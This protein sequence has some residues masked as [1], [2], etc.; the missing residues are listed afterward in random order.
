MMRRLLSGLLVLALFSVACTGDDGLDEETSPSTTI[1]DT[2]TTLAAIDSTTAV[3]PTSFPDPPVEEPEL[4]D[5]NLMRCLD[6][7]CSRIQVVRLDEQEKLPP[8]VCCRPGAREVRVTDILTRS[9]GRPLVM[10]EWFT[11]HLVGEGWDS[12]TVVYSCAD[13]TCSSVTSQVV[14]EGANHWSSVLLP[15]GSLAISFQTG[16]EFLCLEECADPE[17]NDLASLE[18]LICPDPDD[19]SAAGGSGRVVVLDREGMTG[20]W[21]GNLLVGAAGAPTVA[22]ERELGPGVAE[23]RLARCSDPRCSDVSV[24]VVLPAEAASLG[25]G[26]AL[27]DGSPVLVQDRD[28]S[29]RQETRVIACEDPT[30]SSWVLATSFESRMGEPG[31]GHPLGIAVDADGGIHVPLLTS[32]VEDTIFDGY[33]VAMVSCAD[34]FCNSPS[35]SPSLVEH[36]GYTGA[37]ALGPT[38]V[39]SDGRAYVVYEMGAPEMEPAFLAYTVCDDPTCATATTQVL[40]DPALHVDLWDPTSPPGLA[41]FTLQTDTE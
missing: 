20:L 36:R 10:A 1:P 18:L 23:I 34:R 12:Q 9:D 30:C 19:C 14:M 15:D 39:T 5:V 27:P 35:R 26:V 8:M 31:D 40:D 2:T 28:F 37:A 17:R 4:V 22:Y 13:V 29:D 6:A 24:S 3:T 33:S 38:G 16:R 41:M 21:G 25:H 32:I 7:E 11:Q